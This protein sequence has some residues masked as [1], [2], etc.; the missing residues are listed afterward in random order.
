VTTEF[1]EPPPASSAYARP[2]TAPQ[3]GEALLSIT[4][5]FNEAGAAFKANVVVFVLAALVFQILSL[6]SLFILCGPLCG[7]AALLSLRCLLRPDHRADLGDLFGTMHRFLPMVGLFFL[8]LIATLAGVAL[9]VVPALILM[10]LWLYPFYL[11]VDKDLP[12]MDAL[13]ISW[14]IVRR[15]GFGPNFLLAMIALALELVPPVL[16]YV[17]FIVGCVT[18]PLAW[19]VVASAYVQQVREKEEDLRDLFPQGFPVAAAV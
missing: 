18:T 17:G 19:L 1:K 11:M 8:T 5:C 3:R 2:L 4:R 7:G 15:R 12:A 9:L 13:S 10:T 6:V 14:T 16:P